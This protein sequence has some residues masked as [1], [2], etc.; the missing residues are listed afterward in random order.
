[1]NLFWVF[2]YVALMAAVGGAAYYIGET[3][4]EDRGREEAALTEEEMRYFAAGVE[5][6]VQ[7]GHQWDGVVWSAREVPSATPAA[8]P[9]RT[10]CTEI[11]G[12]PYRTESER[13]FFLANC[14]GETV[15]PVPQ[16]GVPEN[17][18]CYDLFPGELIANAP[19]DF[20]DYLECVENFWTGTGYVVR[21]RDGAFSKTGGES[22]ACTGS[23]GVAQPLYSH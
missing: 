16:C 21:C 19:A 6:L 17:P 11:D 20:C 22:D 9:D 3:R 5:T 15:T 18:W 12:T 14:V 8:T 1:M 23:G 13:A 10:S 2:L 7:L 4:G